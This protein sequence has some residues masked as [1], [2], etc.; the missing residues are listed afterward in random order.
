M[1]DTNRAPENRA[2]QGEEK[3]GNVR[4]PGLAREA[5][6]DPLAQGEGGAWETHDR[7]ATTVRVRSGPDFVFSP[8]NRARIQTLIG[9]YPTKQAALL[10]VL[11]LAQDQVLADPDRP[12]Q[13]TSDVIRAVARALDLA[14][15]Y[16][17]GVATFYTM[18]HT[19][20]PI[21]KH[22]I[23][24]CTSVGCHLSGGEQLYRHLCAKL[25]VDPEHGGT[26]TDGTFTLRRAECLAACGYAPMLQLDEGPFIEKLTL[27]D[28]DRLIERLKAGED[29]SDMAAPP[30]GPT[31]PAFEQDGEGR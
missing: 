17:W 13:L 15:A 1:S 7:S 9:R 30:R 26:T 23:E 18:Y 14:P 27:A 28:A 19:K 22:L 5:G 11:W 3:P 2:L 6:L 20:E 29:V 25:Q 4:A 16:V 31:V 8:E 21:G 12:R 10:P 24:V